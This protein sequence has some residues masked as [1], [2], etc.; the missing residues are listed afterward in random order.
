MSTFYGLPEV[1]AQVT[2][3]THLAIRDDAHVLYGFAK[4]AE[5]ELFRALLRVTGVG[6]RIALGILSGMSTQEFGRSVQAADTAALIRLPGVGRKT[7]E[8]LVVELRD[9]LTQPPLA[10][11]GMPLSPGSQAPDSPVNEAV[12]ALVTLGYRPA[13]AD[14][15]VRQVEATESTSEAL[16]RAALKAAARP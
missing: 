1:G 9:R 13:E 8:R 4:E 16:I 10:S 6:A 14:R 3:L 2:L 5:R 12:S 11:G 15:M 7:A